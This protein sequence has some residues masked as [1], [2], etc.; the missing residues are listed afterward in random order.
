[1]KH[2][3]VTAIYYTTPQSRMGGRGYT[4]EFYKAPFRN[5]LNLGCNIVVYS[6]GSEITK[7]EN[8]FKQYSF[9]DY[10]IIDYDLNSYPHS[11]KIYELKEI[12]GIINERGLAVGTSPIQNDRCHH[13]CL[14]KLYFLNDTIENQHF[15]SEKYFWIDAGLFHHGI[16]PETH[17]GIEKFV[18]VVEEKYW[19]HNKNNIC[20]P[21]M[22]DK[23]LIKNNSEMIFL[24][25]ENGWIVGGLFG[26]S[27]NVVKELY[28]DFQELST[29]MLYE[30]DLTLEEKVLSK[31]VDMKYKKYNYISF[32]IWHHDVP[33]VPNY[34]GAP[35]TA[36]SFYK[37]FI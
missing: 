36:K 26:G 13:L 30:N 4:F 24:G 34:F 6:H 21:E 5:I 17:G 10:K 33:T 31:L 25:M 16:F 22:I 8:F 1:M 2:T 7:I 14:S 23:L 9:N 12:N 20:T 19:P 37:I 35:P 29:T 32:G 11:D 15:T 3:L 27:K 28:V 18:S